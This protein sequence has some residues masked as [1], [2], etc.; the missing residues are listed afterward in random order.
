MD[1]KIALSTF[2]LVFLAE[3]GDKTQL[4]A[5]AM[6]VKS[7]SPMAVFVGAVAALALVTLVGVSLGEAVANLIPAALLQKVSGALFVV[8]GVA[9]L[10]FG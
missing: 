3:L 2:G 9:I 6:A 5:I 10:L 8:I 7:R 1:W 4:A